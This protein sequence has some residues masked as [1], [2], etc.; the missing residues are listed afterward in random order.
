MTREADLDDLDLDKLLEEDDFLEDFEFDESEGDF[1]L[2][3]DG[4]PLPSSTAGS[5]PSSPV[6]PVSAVAAVPDAGGGERGPGRLARLAGSRWLPMLCYVGSALVLVGQLF[7]AG[8]MINNRRQPV[9]SSPQVIA[10]V[11]II[12]PGSAATPP[13]TTDAAVE[14]AEI[15]P[16]IISFHYVY[17]LYSLAG[18]RVLGADVHLVFAVGADRLPDAAEI[19]AGR[20]AVSVALGERVGRR[21]ME[22]IEQREQLF[23]RFIIDTLTDFFT[24]RGYPL[25]SVQ[26]ENFDIT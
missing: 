13:S 6:A 18:L 21:M 23:T 8:R 7:L 17:Q 12:E 4:L 2:D 26:L 1:Y 19:S 11:E 20:E 25:E 9:R 5:A 22:E 14:K 24:G 3:G 16:E 10:L 15:A